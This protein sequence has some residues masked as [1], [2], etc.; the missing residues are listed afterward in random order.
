MGDSNVSLFSYISALLAGTS[1]HGIGDKLWA[2]LSVY[3]STET[4]NTFPLSYTEIFREK[5]W[6]FR[7]KKSKLSVHLTATP[8]QDL[9]T[10][11]HFYT[12]QGWIISILFV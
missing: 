7:Q 11:R 3:E 6:T 12:A 8:D 1:H 2:D 10:I 9:T 4:E 5:K